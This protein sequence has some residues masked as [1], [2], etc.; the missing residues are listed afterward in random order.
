MAVDLGI[1]LGTSTTLICDENGEVLLNEPSLVI[2]SN[3]SDQVVAIGSAASD[4]IGRTPE[5]V[6]AI[7][8]IRGGAITAYNATVA[9]LKY[10]IKQVATASFSRVRA[11]ISVPCGI[12]PV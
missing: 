5:G 3:T 12:S 10:F 4:M 9:M 2:K 7:M 6:S 8:P 1:D 11:V